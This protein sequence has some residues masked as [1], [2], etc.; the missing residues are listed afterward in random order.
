MLAPR[1]ALLRSGISC[2]AGVSRKLI[3]GLHIQ[4]TTNCLVIR[5]L[6]KSDC[7]SF[8]NSD[9]E[10]ISEKKEEAVRLAYLTINN[11]FYGCA[12]LY[13]SFYAVLCFNFYSVYFFLSFFRLYEY[14]QVKLFAYSII[15]ER[16]SFRKYSCVI[17]ARAQIHTQQITI[18]R[19][20][21]L[22]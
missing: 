7:Q 17:F 21:N 5:K 3:G 22:C 13:W 14:I 10:N 2:L 19:I 9:D 11:P 16:I 15:C 8:T 6:T 18:V 1:C 4:L 20:S 12:I